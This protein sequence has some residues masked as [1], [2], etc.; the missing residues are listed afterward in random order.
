M[1]EVLL[2]SWMLSSFISIGSALKSTGNSMLLLVCLRVG[3]QNLTMQ[4]DTSCLAAS[5]DR[6]KSD[7]WGGRRR[8]RPVPD[9]IGCCA[10]Q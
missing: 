6:T 9:A 7:N 3:L 2:V 4:S 10:S 8:R 5:Q 1:S